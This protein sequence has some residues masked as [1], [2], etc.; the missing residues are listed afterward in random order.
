MVAAID[1]YPRVLNA[2]DL[3]GLPRIGNVRLIELVE[4]GRL[5]VIV[6]DQFAKP[7][8]RVFVEAWPADISTGLT[9]DDFPRP[10]PSFDPMDYGTVHD[11]QHLISLTQLDGTYT[12]PQ[13]PCG[14]PLLI[15]ASGIIVPVQSIVTI[16]HESREATVVLEAPPSALA[17]GR[18]V[19]EDN[20]PAIRI[21]VQAYGIH[22]QQAQSPLTLSDGNGEFQLPG[23]PPG[24]QTWRIDNPGETLRQ[25]DCEGAVVNLGTMTLHRPVEVSGR[26]KTS[27]CASTSDLFIA[28][29]CIQNKTEMDVVRLT[30][31]EF[32]LRAI[33]GPTQLAVTTV[34]G[35][36]LCEVNVEAPCKDVIINID[37]CASDLTFALVGTDNSRRD[38]LVELEPWGKGAIRGRQEASRAE[39]G[40]SSCLSQWSEGRVAMH[41]VPPGAYTLHVMQRQGGEACV[42]GIVLSAKQ[43][44]DAGAIVLGKGAIRGHVI[45]TT[46]TG[47]AGIGINICR[48]RQFTTDKTD[49]LRST[50]SKEGGVFEFVSVP[51]TQWLVYPESLGVDSEA[52]HTV[53]V[54][55]AEVVDV[56]LVSGKPGCACGRVTLNGFPVRNAGVV[57]DPRRGRWHLESK[58]SSTTGTDGSYNV[59]GLAPGDYVIHVTAA[60]NMESLVC[61]TRYITLAAGERHVL[62]IELG[63]GETLLSFVQD[64]SPFGGIDR[65]YALWSDGASR[66]Q[67]STPAQGALIAH[68]GRGPWLFVLG[69]TDSDIVRSGVGRH[70]S[71]V[72]RCGASGESP[73]RKLQLEIPKG[74]LTIRL[75]SNDQ[76]ERPACEYIDVYGTPV[77][78]GFGPAVSPLEDL[79]PNGVQAYSCIPTGARL[80]VHGLDEQGTM[81]SVEM[82]KFG[83]IAEQ[84]VW[85]PR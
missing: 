59:L 42:D 82:V 23:L 54:A 46:G 40:D 2:A 64:G 19:W 66:L 63:D 49:N 84:L 72:M 30:A 78:P 37:D 53:T 52:A 7:I 47:V 85:P 36:Q 57:V 5:H 27:L 25:M 6:H 71:I 21:R 69:T 39:F 50:T 38:L 9:A 8:A 74:V 76:V 10:W 44:Y 80:R 43:S 22:G 51:A 68:L 75:D 3:R 28:L 20:Q 24:K 13:M 26:V 60:S 55:P 45:D 15:R 48:R 16:P 73:P 56:S 70:G 67:R 33:A 31:D 65:G 58:H 1:Y 35:R 79:L 81:R 11:N 77:A 17:R 83:D 32:T 41:L 34:E 29:H 14:M 12:I 62:D 18:L 61:E 4:S